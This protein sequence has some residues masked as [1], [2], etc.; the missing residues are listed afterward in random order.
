MGRSRCSVPP[1]LRVVVC[2][3]HA[4]A[5]QVVARPFLRRSETMLW[6]ARRSLGVQEE[7]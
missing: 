4:V 7:K 5:F 2:L 3:V 1:L 6:I